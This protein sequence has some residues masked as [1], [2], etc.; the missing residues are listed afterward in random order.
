[1]SC[2]TE[3]C[4]RNTSISTYDDNF[5]TNGNYDGYPSWSGSSNGYFIYFK[6][7]TTQWCLSD[8]LGGDCLLSGKSPCTTECPDLFDLYLSSG[9]CPTPT[10][11][12]TNNCSVLDF[13]SFFDCSPVDFIT[14]TPTPTNSSTPTPTP[15]STNA[16]GILRVNA[17][18]NSLTPSP[19]QT[20]TITPTSSSTIIRNLNFSGDV[21]FNTVDTNINC[22][23]SKQFSA[24]DDSNTTYTTTNVLVNPSGGVITKDMVFNAIVDG[25]PKC[26]SYIG[27]TYDIIGNNVISL[28]TGPLGFSYD[29]GCELCLTPPTPTPTMTMTPTPTKPL[30][31]YCARPCPSALE[32][33]NPLLSEELPPLGFS[34][35]ASPAYRKIA[36]PSGLPMGTTIKATDGFCYYLT[37][38]ENPEYTMGPKLTQQGTSTYINCDEC[39]PAPTPTPTPTMTPTIGITNYLAEQCCSTTQYWRLPNGTLTDFSTAIPISDCEDMSTS[40]RAA[41]YSL[42]NLYC[43]NN[44]LPLPYISYQTQPCGAKAIFIELPDLETLIYV[45]NN[46]STL[47]AY[48][49]LNNGTIYRD[50]DCCN[51]PYNPEDYMNN[52][53]NTVSETISSLNC[54]FSYVGTGLFDW[55]NRIIDLSGGDPNLHFYPYRDLSTNQCMVSGNINTQIVS[56]TNNYTPLSNSLKLNDDLCYDI[57][58]VSLLPPTIIWTP[59]TIYEDCSSCQS[60]IPPSEYWY[61]V[62]KCIDTQ[63]TPPIYVGDCWTNPLQPK[64]EHPTPTL[65]IG[66]TFTGTDGFCYSVTEAILPV[67][68]PS[69]DGPIITLNSDTTIQCWNCQTFRLNYITNLPESSC[70][71]VETDYVYYRINNGSWISL[72]VL[73]DN[74]SGTDEILNII[75]SVGTVIDYYFSTNNNRPWG[76]GF[77]SGDFSSK[78]GVI[79]TVTMTTYTFIVM[80][81]GTNVSGDDC[82]FG[83]PCTIPECCNLPN[84][85]INTQIWTACNLDV[86]T[87][88]NGN[89]IQH[90]TDPTEWANTTTGAWCY[91]E[92]NSVTGCTYGK[93]YNWYAVN[94]PRGLA[95]SGYHIPTEAEWLTLYNELGGD[96]LAGGPLK[97][98]GFSHWLTPNDGA[99]NSSSFSALPGGYRDE[100][101]SFSSINTLGL[102]WGSEAFDS[103]DAWNRYISY[104]S[105][106]ISTAYFS[107]NSGT[108][109][110]LIKDL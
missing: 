69:I 38:R 43:D 72:P 84:A 90:I 104:D 82:Q 74:Y 4:V 61:C 3:Y 59:P 46:D 66:T 30:A 56:I 89:L 54:N 16:C 105:T 13:N 58:S 64:V 5:S 28:T 9:I 107:K 71:T 60:T 12:P 23:I 98:S 53:T 55:I 40:A 49:I 44:E 94:D 50:L 8:N 34:C 77:N 73:A 29:G 100:F 31:W 51:N 87:Y 88:S 18:I 78:C 36:L 24:C 91:Y 57:K 79:E 47:S 62:T 14:P 25:Q 67:N 22:P 42:V 80:N 109:V 70:N 19:T 10:P 86:E 2:P 76:V 92:N 75:V 101:G 33:S 106:I 99:T 110:R 103:V 95:P 35:W 85:T 32:Q 83:L 7:G 1:M 15:T 108:S 102:W 17:V 48:I 81:L 27:V 93:L 41:R 26:I 45:Q 65:S 11:T 52:L 39:N 68:Y 96:N 37:E 63:Q 21:T 97:E 20:P 6:T